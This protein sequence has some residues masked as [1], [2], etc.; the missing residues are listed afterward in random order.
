MNE[1]GGFEVNE[2]D[3]FKTT[4]FY[5]G[6]YCGPTDFCLICTPSVTTMGQKSSLIQRRH[7]GLAGSPLPR[8]GAAGHH[9]RR[10]GRD[11][12]LELAR[13]IRGPAGH[14]RGPAQ[15]LAGHGPPGAAR[16][17]GLRADS[18]TGGTW[19]GARK[20]VLRHLE[21]TPGWPRLRRQRPLQRG[22]HHGRGGGG[23]RPRHQGQGR[24]RTPRECERLQG[25]PDDWTAGQS[26]SQRYKQLGNGVAVPVFE[27]VAARLIAQHEQIVGAA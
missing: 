1:E 15:Q 16:R 12:E 23:L 5:F 19:S 2:N 21:R 17:G 18:R 27:W 13:G 26:D 22:R 25:H 20:A 8:A 11:R 7:H 4:I 9:A 24:R 3:D 6:Y 14:C 10:E